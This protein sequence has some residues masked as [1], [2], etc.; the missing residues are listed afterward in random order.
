[1]GTT[2]IPISDELLAALG[3]DQDDAP[4]AVAEAAV[5]ELYRRGT[6]SAGYA[7]NL[8]GIDKWEFVRWSGRLGIPYFRLTPEELANEL[9][10]LRSL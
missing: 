2:N 3:V 5:L 1:M 4:R 8:L 10:V 7:A 9:D 6:I